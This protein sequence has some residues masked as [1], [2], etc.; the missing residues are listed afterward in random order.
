MPM[1]HGSGKGIRVIP[2]F[3]ELRPHLQAAYDALPEGADFLIQRTRNPTVNLRTALLRLM[4]R[5]GVKPWEK[6]WQSMRSSRATELAVEH[7]AHV[8]A[9]WAGH[10]QE[11]AMNHYWTVTDADYTK[12]LVV[13]ESPAPKAAAPADDTAQRAVQI[14]AHHHPE[15]TRTA[16][17]T[18]MPSESEGLVV[19][20]LAFSCGNSQVFRMGEEGF[21]PPKT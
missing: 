10:T 7:P 12:A 9:A 16:P 15:S 20:E 4:A 17:Q 8:A 2:L 11:V 14:Q 19:R 6:L 21:E 1:S 13:P 18:D 3:P 5:A